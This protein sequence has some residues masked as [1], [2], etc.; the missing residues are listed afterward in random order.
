MKIIT[1]DQII[2]EL[3][4]IRENASRGVEVLHAAEI[5]MLRTELAM[6]RAEAIAYL[7]SEGSIG[8]RN[9][10]VTL[11]VEDEALDY[12]VTKAEYNRV[13]TKLKQLELSQMSV[14]TQA[15]LVE[16]TYRT[17]GVGQH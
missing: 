13:K 6:D 16:L 2:N 3:I 8:E 4:D 12:A 9:A 10:K 15:K 5:K 14:Q 11:M 1:P 7:N 17:A